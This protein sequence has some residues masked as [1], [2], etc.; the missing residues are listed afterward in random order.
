MTEEKKTN[1]KNIFTPERTA[2]YFFV[3]LIG[4]SIVAL[5]IWPLL[6]MLF[7]QIDKTTFTYSVKNHI[8]V[9]IILDSFLNELIFNKLARK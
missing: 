5:I 3:S 2:K 4:T 8:I 1:E 7:T 6:D 9:P